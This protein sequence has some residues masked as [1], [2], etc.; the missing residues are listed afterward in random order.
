MLPSGLTQ[1]ERL[2]LAAL[3]KNLLTQA[4]IAGAAF[5]SYNRAAG[6]SQAGSKYWATRQYDTARSA[7]TGGQRFRTGDGTC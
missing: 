7:S 3:G 6:A 4:A 1:Q 5:T 2:A